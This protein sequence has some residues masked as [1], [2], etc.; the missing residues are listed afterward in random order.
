[1]P[2][3]SSKVT[4]IILSY[5][6]GSYLKDAIESVI[7]QTY[8]NL[9]IIISDNGSN[10]NSKEIIKNYLDDKRIIFL[11]YDK[12]EKVTKRCNAA[13]KI[14]TGEYISFLYSDDYYHDDKIKT[15]VEILDSLDH[16]WGVVHGPVIR[17]DQNK[18]E[19]LGRVTNAHD[20]CF[21]YLL[22][23]YFDG[24]INPISPLSRIDCWKKYPSYEDVF[25]EGEGLFLR[26]AMEYKFFYLEKPLAFM[27]DH[28]TNT[29]KALKRNIQTHH[30]MIKKLIHETKFNQKHLHLVTSHSAKFKENVAWHT[31]RS[32]GDKSFA[33]QA[34]MWAIRTKPTI[35]LSLRTF[36]GIFLTFLPNVFLKP[37]NT[38]IDT[39]LRKKPFKVIEDYYQ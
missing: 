11:D 27:R 7:N 28:K 35:I 23:N 26:F 6:Q 34:F 30:T 14:A 32:S 16:T 38:V 12:N 22:K 1:M 20:Y 39:T 2:R 33:R 3:M 29:G 19:S 36:I 8:Q 18:F 37:L 9:E 13:I 15:Q 5:N 4:V 31:V 25:I 24:F 21:E 10:D 17:I